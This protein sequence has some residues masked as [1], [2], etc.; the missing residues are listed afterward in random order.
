MKIKLLA[1]SII[2]M[3]ASAYSQPSAPVNQAH[4]PVNG[5]EATLNT[6]PLHVQK[7]AMPPI[8]QPAQGVPPS[9]MAPHANKEIAMPEFA[10][11]IIATVL[12]DASPRVTP[13]PY[14]SPVA[15]QS[16]VKSSSNAASGSIAIQSTPSSVKDTDLTQT[17]KSLGADAPKT[18]QAMPSRKDVSASNIGSSINAKLEEGSAKLEALQ[19]QEQ[20]AIQTLTNA[21][22]GSSTITSKTKE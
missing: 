1:P 8:R 11:E 5:P 15:P 10:P 22:S 3:S 2:L 13:K 18:S 20:I 21:N 16:D 6:Q 7:S 12:L 17:T 9:E 19:T 14:P 4:M